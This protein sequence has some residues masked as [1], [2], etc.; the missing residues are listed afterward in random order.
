MNTQGN[1]RSTGRVPLKIAELRTGLVCYCFIGAGTAGDP[2]ER[3]IQADTKAGSVETVRVF[4]ALF[5][6]SY[7]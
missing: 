2:G 1:G 4:A 3:A 7:R 5:R 6:D